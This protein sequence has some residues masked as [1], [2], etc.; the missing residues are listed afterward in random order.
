MD[1]NTQLENVF[2]L[3]DEKLKLS[4]NGTVPDIIKRELY[5]VLTELNLTILPKTGQITTTDADNLSRVIMAWVNTI[6]EENVVID[7]SISQILYQLTVEG[8]IIIPPR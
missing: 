3:L 7:V 6:P 8:W 4:V 1:L 5:S 2:S